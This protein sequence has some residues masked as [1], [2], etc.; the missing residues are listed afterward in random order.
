MGK[1]ESQ[2]RP[3]E[4]GLVITKVFRMDGEDRCSDLGGCMMKGALVGKWVVRLASVT[5]HTV[6][7][8]G[9][10]QV[11]KTITVTHLSEYNNASFK[12]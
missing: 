7:C 1:K 8:S 9:S 5:G 6:S 12:T 4:N 10:L 11:A 2:S 3:F